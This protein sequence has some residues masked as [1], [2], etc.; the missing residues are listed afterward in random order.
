MFGMN[1][2][3]EL[4]PCWSESAISTAANMCA[5]LGGVGRGTSKWNKVVL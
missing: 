4:R 5:F 3:S 1:P 2:I